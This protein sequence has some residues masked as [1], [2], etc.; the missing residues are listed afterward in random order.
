MERLLQEDI[1]CKIFHLG[2]DNSFLFFSQA[3][4]YDPAQ[5]LQLAESVAQPQERSARGR[6]GGDICPKKNLNYGAGVMRQVLMN[7]LPCTCR[8]VESGF[9][10][11]RHKLCIFV[12]LGAGQQ[13]GV[14]PGQHLPKKVSLP[15]R[16]GSTAKPVQG[17]VCTAA[18]PVHW[19]GTSA[20]MGGEK[21]EKM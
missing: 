10:G 3:P 1:S 16:P 2:T 13:V 18:L 11:L 4:G 19:K 20:R 12:T 15:K 8:A 6:G 9:S 21:E 14:H 17:S 5:D 7:V